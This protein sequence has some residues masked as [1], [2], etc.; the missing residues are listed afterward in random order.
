[1]GN[2]DN[3]IIVCII[4]VEIECNLSKYKLAV[5]LDSFYEGHVVTET[6][7]FVSVKT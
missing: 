1:M 3:Y 6:I 2:Y 7:E 5:I 4:V